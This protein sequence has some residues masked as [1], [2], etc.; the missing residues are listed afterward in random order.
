M[1][2]TMIPTTTTILTATSTAG[3]T[4]VTTRPLRRGHP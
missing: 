1:T 4:P 2:E 3:V